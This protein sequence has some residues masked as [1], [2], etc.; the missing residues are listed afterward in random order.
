MRKYLNTATF[1]LVFGLA[2][3]VF[4]REFTKLN[5]FEGQTSLGLVHGHTIILGFMLFLIIM[6]LDKLFNLSDVKA[7]SKWYVLYNLSLLY[8]IGTFIARG[9]LDVLG[10]DFAGLN[11]IAGLG[12]ALLGG[13]LIWFVV[14]LYKKIK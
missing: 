9:V 6:I 3:G 7:M 4:H 10:K 2:L 13:S 12:H 8:T 11:H 1:Y 5:G 14:I